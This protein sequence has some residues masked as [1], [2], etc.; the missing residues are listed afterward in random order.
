MCACNREEYVETTLQ[1]NTSQCLSRFPSSIDPKT[2]HGFI[3]PDPV[4]S[5]VTHVAHPHSHR[6][7]MVLHS[8]DRRSCGGGIDES[9]GC[10]EEDSSAV[11]RRRER[12]ANPSSSMVINLTDVNCEGSVCCA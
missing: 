11:E 9:S 10:S 1:E 3:R 6:I 12:V 4:M 5:L 2:T 8:A 7:P